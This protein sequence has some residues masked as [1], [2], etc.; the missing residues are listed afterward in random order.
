MVEALEQAGLRVTF[1]KSPIESRRLLQQVRPAVVVLDPFVCTAGGVEFE[2]V[3][4]LQTR[5]D[6]VP[7]IVAVGEPAELLEVRKVLAP[8]KDFLVRPF[9]PDELRHRVEQ[10]LV[11]K[12][13]YVALQDHARRL[14]GEVIRDFKTGLYTERHLRHLLRQ[15]FTRAER[16][17]SPLS[18]LLIDVDDFKRINDTCDYAFGDH[19][20]TQLAGILLRSIREIDHA[21]RFGGDEFIVLLP[22]TT[23]AE[24]VQVAHRFRSQLERRVFD[25][26]RYQTRITTSI[27]IDTFDGRSASSPDELRRR[28]NQALKEAKARGKNKIW[29]YSGES[30]AEA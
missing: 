8:F 28:A 3:A 22:S 6:P 14:E 7:L 9:T 29:L 11:D 2:L 21:A 12:Q 27:G 13:R 16:H 18:F 20:L 19:V 17:R 4:S 30:V 24:A 10:A 5:E 23:P 15:E 1:S 25:D 26:G